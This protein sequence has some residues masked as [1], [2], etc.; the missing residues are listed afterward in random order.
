MARGSLIRNAGGGSGGQVDMSVFVPTDEQ[1]AVHEVLLRGSGHVLVNA[2]AGSGK[3]RTITE[4]A[5]L[6]RRCTVGLVAFN[7]HIA[8]ELQARMA[9]QSNVQCMTYHSLGYKAVRQ[10]VGYLGRPDQYRVLG[11]LDDMHLPIAHDKEKVVKYRTATLVSLAKQY[12]Y[13]KRKDLEWLMDW[14]DIDANGETELI[15]D[16][17]P[18]ILKLCAEVCRGDSIDFDDMIWLPQE[19]GLEVPRFDVLCVDESQD[20]G[21]TQ[22][23]LAT[24]AGNR[25]C[26]IGD[27]HQCH[28]PGT[29]VQMTGGGTKNIEDVVVGEQVVT[30]HSCSSTF[31]GL[32][33]QGRRVEELHEEYFS[34]SLVVLRAGSTEVSCT[35]NHRWLTRLVERDKDNYILYLMVRQDRARIG[36]CRMHYR[37]SSGL[38]NRARTEKAEK[39]WI[40]QAFDSLHEARVAELVA[41]SQFGLPSLIFEQNM[42]LSP[43]ADPEFIHAVYSAIGDLIPRAKDCLKWYG[44][45]WEFPLWEDHGSNNYI[46]RYSFVTE[47]CNLISG[48]MQVRLFDNDTH[49][50]QWRVVRTSRRRYTG[51]VY[52]IQVEPTEGGR[53]LYVANDIVSHN[54]I[55]QWRGADADSMGRLEAWM[56][57]NGGC[58]V[59]PLTLTR[60]CPKSHV[61][62]A[63]TI[64]PQIHALEDAAEGEVR[65]MGMD[66]ACEVMRP[67]D[68]VVCRV[69]A[70][71]M[72]CAYRILKRGVK[73]VVR[74]RDVGK[75]LLRLIEEAEKSAGSKAELREV[76]RACEGITQRAVEKFNAIAHGRGEARAMAAVDKFECVVELG[77]GVES[78]S[79]LKR[80]IGD[81]FADFEADGTP[82]HAVILGTVHRTKGLE[83]N[84]VFVLRPDLMPHKMARKPH[85][86]EGE[87][88]LAYVAVTRAKFERGNPDSGVLVFV[89]GESSL[90]RVDQDQTWG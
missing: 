84:R 10:A 44:R 16:T 81:L 39:A 47:A 2:V 46:G 66:A 51:K 40:L 15:L 68:L 58:T 56:Q 13:K 45:E 77:V 8:D 87:L 32:S 65:Y 26:A 63:Q 80:V 29:Q 54:S 43:S 74:G 21:R 73:A 25:I 30:Y 20:T 35:D 9:G 82:K 31:R 52:G 53:R 34:G 78:T 71:L 86:R 42:N 7:K 62:L 28:P 60:R 64:V 55:Y 3:T 5:R 57:D 4:Y 89:G 33:T 69:N 50:G 48:F 90:F 79:E 37:S 59:L 70:E 61:R 22:H 72:G 23:W 85:E 12:G 38:G 83:A 75:G 27:R 49:G 6:E 88:N 17:V 18:K 14:H 67:G 11:M 36:L 24:H 19:L 1:Q 76:L 41:Q